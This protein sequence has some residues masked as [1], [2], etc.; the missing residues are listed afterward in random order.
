[1]RRMRAKRYPPWIS[2]GCLALA[3]SLAGCGS[4]DRAPTKASRFGR[5]HAVR[6]STRRAE[7]R[8]ERRARARARRAQARA[9]TRKRQ[10]AALGCP[11]PSRVL[12]GVY[13]PDRLAVRDPCRRVTGT[14][15]LV[16]PP[17][18]DGD[19]HFDVR[20]QTT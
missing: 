7:P 15:I 4:S 3:L 17:E 16:R 6:Q 20:W 12:D 14:V 2:V 13:H 18:E 8:R 11:D 1:M 9:R 10:L 19:L 5:T